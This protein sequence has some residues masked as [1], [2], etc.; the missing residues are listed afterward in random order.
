MGR[1]TTKELYYKLGQK[2]DGLRVKS[3]WNEDLYELLKS[4]YTA[5][6]A[7]LIL[8][9]PYFFSDFD[10][11]QRI[12][13]YEENKLRG[14]LET[15]CTKGV[16]IDLYRNDRYYYLLSPMMIGIFEF[17]MMRTGQ[18]SK[19]TEWAN[20]FHSYLTNSD[21]YYKANWQEET[22]VPL[23]RSIP[24][25]ET[26]APEY[27][28]EVLDYELAEAIAREQDLC[29]ISICQCRREKEHAGVK[30]CDKPMHTCSTFGYGTE[31][32]VRRNMA[33]QVSTTEMLENMARSKEAGLAFTADNVST[34]AMYIC[35]CCGC[36]CNLFQGINVHGCLTAVKSSNFI[37]R[38]DE[39]NC[40]GCGKCARACPINAIDM[41]PDDGVMKSGKKRKKLAKIDETMCL[42]CGV[43]GL[44][45]S[46]DSLTLV[47]REARVLHPET[48]LERIALQCL[49]NGNL[50]NQVFDDPSSISHNF[51]RVFMGAFFRLSPVKKALMSDMLRS[52][53][54]GVAKGI[55]N[56]KGLGWVDKL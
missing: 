13:K 54:F 28:N 27:Q 2:I 39:S 38:I 30:E 21:L 15:L 48:T 17:V 31:Y 55:M 10:R 40:N 1:M 33:K 52:T 36:C 14:M 53:F 46:F 23:S 4:I 9:L 41:V 49:E 20:R 37:A 47:K 22:R 19:T 24:H 45:C 7:E 29:G 44:K 32:L 42:G 16:L 18:G 6:E 12:T 43:C 56:V 34:R 11:I 8:K 26:V 3:P 35:H 51:M 5:E 25:V 50:A